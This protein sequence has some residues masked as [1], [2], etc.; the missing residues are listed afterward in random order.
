MK[1][2]GAE[3]QRRVRS[4]CRTRRQAGRSQGRPR[5]QASK[6]GKDDHLVDHPAAVCSKQ[7]RGATKDLGERRQWHRMRH[8]HAHRS[9]T[10]G[11][12]RAQ[13]RRLHA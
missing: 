10:G 5:Q 1:G 8:Q 11:A 3:R 7:Q 13:Y 4:R 2:G 9:E 6:S 12:Y